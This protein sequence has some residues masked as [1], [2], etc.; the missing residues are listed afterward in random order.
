LFNSFAIKIPMSH[1]NAFRSPASLWPTC[2][3]IE[4]IKM[5]NQG[6]FDETMNESLILMVDLDVDVELCD[7]RMLLWNS[8]AGYLISKL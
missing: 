3:T 1:W 8:S 6:A 4:R 2:K 7:A 5:L